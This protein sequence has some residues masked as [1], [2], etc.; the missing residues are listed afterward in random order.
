MIRYLRIALRYLLYSLLVLIVLAAGAVAVLTLTERGRSS[1]AG[2]ASDL[3]SGPGR[4]VRI[5]GIDGIWSGNLTAAQVVVEDK[6]GP[7]AALT[8]VSVDWSP[9][10]LLGF[11]FDAERVSAHRVEITRLPKAAET[12]TDGS[13]N[14]PVTIDIA[15]VDLPDIRLGEALAGS[16]ARFSATGSVLVDNAPLAAEATLA[17]ERTDSRAGSLT[18]DIAFVPD[19][20]RL[21]IEINGSEPQGGVIATL[22]RLPEAPSVEINVSGSGP[23]ADW[24]GRATFA[25]DGDV[26]AAVD[27]R[28]Q[29]TD[30]GSRIE[31]SGTGDFHAFLPD[32]F[33]AVARGTTEF[34]FAG[35]VR[36]WNAITVDTLTLKGETVE[37]SARGGLDPEGVS[38]FEFQAQAT[39]APVP[40]RFGDGEARIELALRNASGR[41]FGP[42]DALGFNIDAELARLSVS[43]LAAE[44]IALT[45]SSQAFDFKSRSGPVSLS[46]TSAAV[47]SSI[48]TL[49]NL[50]AGAVSLDAQTVVSADAVTLENAVLRS[51]TVSAQATGR[52]GIADTTVTIDLTGEMLSAVL[53]PASAI[54]FGRDIKLSGRLERSADGGLSVSGAEMQSGD[55]SV[56][57]SASMADETI[58]ADIN[59]T[60][61]DLSRLSA[62]AEGGAAFSLQASGDIAKPQVNVTVSSD[63]LTVAGRELTGLSLDASVTADRAAPAGD[64]TLTGQIGSDQLEGK[65]TLATNDGRRE[66][67]DLG[68]SLGENQLSGALTLDDAFVP[69]GTV[70]FDFP[71]I[72]PLAALVLVDVSG[73][74]NGTIRFVRDGGTPRLS[75]EGTVP[76]FAM[77]TLSANG[78]S[79]SASA[80]NYIEAPVVSGTVRADRVAA[81]GADIRDAQVNLSRD[82]AWTA[83]DGSATANGTPASAA[84]RVKVEDGDVTL[85]L[86]KAGAT[87]RGLNAAL[88]APTI[89]TVTDGTARLDGL[90]VN[91]AGGNVTISG[92]AG[93]SLNLTARIS[94][95]PASAVTAFAP[96]LGAEG[97]VSGNVNIDGTVSSPQVAYDLNWTG[98]G[99]AQTRSAGLGAMSVSSRG[100]YSGNAVRFNATVGGGS[101][102]TMTGGGSV[103]MRGRS[104]DVTFNGR[105]PFSLLA[106][107]L[108][109]QGMALNGGADVSLKIG[110]GFGA[111]QISGTVR[112]SGARLVHAPTGVAVDDL[113]AAIDI[114][115]GIATITSLEGRLST[116]GSITGN[117]SVGIDPA[118]GFPADL[119]LRIDNGRYTDGRM[120]TANFDGLLA[121]EGPI[122]NS[123]LLSGEINLGR[124]VVT[125]PD[126]LPTSLSQLDV[127][128]RNAPAA[129]ARQQEALRPSTGGGPGG[130]VRLDL[131]LRAPQE[132]FVQGRGLDAELGGSLQLTGPASAVN[133]LGQFEM[134]RGRVNIL[135]RRLDFTR[136]TLSFSGSLVPYLNFAAD[137]RAGDATVTVLV[138]GPANNPSFNFESSP[139]LPED[140]ILARL[141]FDKAMSGLSAVQI[142]QLAS[143]AGQLAGIGGSTTLL[144]RLRERIGVDDIDVSTDEETGDTSV[145]VGKYL[146]D[147]TYLSVE[148]GAQP[149]SGKATIDLDIGGGVKLRGEASD[150]GGTG[151][152]IF[153]EKEY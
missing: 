95:F 139:I 141:L 87:Y 122:T 93:S 90:A 71:E 37:A 2:I 79:V 9:T 128:H 106:G 127:Q 63:R 21:Y 121:L 46:A 74:A 8:D 147:R 140:E 88:A 42:G 81:S 132:I 91:A 15:A 14:L 44:D 131:N 70:Q 25:V 137:T 5:S 73:A 40:L 129:V 13:F 11:A 114:G 118:Q 43:D 78:V 80:D 39:A 20:N 7:W 123:P 33:A 144:Q 116:G 35:L 108:A 45:A 58:S 76:R 27:G 153:Y 103:D 112:T 149:G 105:V 4:T 150:S 38:D 107:R 85:E 96:G 59:G 57:G 53:P 69:E 49:A 41:A 52:Y 60:L 6:T 97:T 75:I 24:K 17:V 64:I 115:G 145:S 31:A 104:A 136:G 86:A 134:R 125:I 102:L 54:L 99:T 12:E 72:G 89:V 28:H 138:T 113:A 84:G 109:A 62:V 101:G 67:G 1:L 100:T 29:L 18:A 16:A 3:A 36:P 47:G 152:G 142:A 10:A 32:G 135:S 23:A 111:P 148:K 77:E 92:T 26:T 34:T 50:L 19:E 68:L 130:G 124:S 82:G 117:G 126:R 133:A 30:A 98:G 66:I 94:S 110:G 48:P 143:A 22:L 65:A 146:N 56:S 83:F 61:T 151:G 55:L 119:N 120:V 51:G